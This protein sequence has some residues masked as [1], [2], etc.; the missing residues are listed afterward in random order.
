MKAVFLSFFSFM[1]TILAAIKR[2]WE[3]TKVALVWPQTFMRSLTR[4][5]EDVQS[6]YGSR[7]ES[8]SSRITWQY[9]LAAPNYHSL[10]WAF[11]RVPMGLQAMIVELTPIS[12]ITTQVNS[13]FGAIW[14]VP[15]PR[16]IKMLFTSWRPP[17]KKKND[18][19]APILSENIK[20][21][22]GNCY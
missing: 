14:L 15:Q 6:F 16:N 4:N 5:F 21:L 7:L 2:W 3:R 17:A 18:P 22:F 19:R 8:V 1:I 9:V 11:D 13:A 20:Q 12:I 10:S